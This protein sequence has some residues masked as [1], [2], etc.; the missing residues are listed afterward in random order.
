MTSEEWIVPNIKNFWLLPGVP[1][2]AEYSRA[3]W[4]YERWSPYGLIPRQNLSEFA[5]E[6]PLVAPGL[7]LVFSLTMLVGSYALDLA[8]GNMFRVFGMMLCL[9]AIVKVLIEWNYRP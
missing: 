8:W 9:T 2:T 1:M 4:V 3:K 5:V 7:A 6:G